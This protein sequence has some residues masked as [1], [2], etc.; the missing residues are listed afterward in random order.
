MNSRLRKFVVTD[1]DVE[2]GRV[3]DGAA[4]TYQHEVLVVAMERRGAVVRRE[5]GIVFGWLR[6]VTDGWLIEVA[7]GGDL[8]PA[9]QALIQ[10]WA[11]SA[12][13]RLAVAPPSSPSHWAVE[14]G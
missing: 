14:D 1:H 4:D 11:K 10:K 7:L 8:N 13:A 12:G 2:V 3:I 5:S 6:E 9:R